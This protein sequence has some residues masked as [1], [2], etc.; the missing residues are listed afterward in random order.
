MQ[1]GIAYG[2]ENSV[3][4]IEFGQF[5]YYCLLLIVTMVTNKVYKEDDTTNKGLC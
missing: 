4:N 1:L 5:V 2:E 3:T